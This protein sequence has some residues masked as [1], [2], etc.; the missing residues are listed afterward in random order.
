M[1]MNMNMLSQE[2]PEIDLSGFQVVKSDI[3]VVG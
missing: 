1:L 2:I 3:P